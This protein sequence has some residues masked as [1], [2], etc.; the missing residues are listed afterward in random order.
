MTYTKNCDC[1]CGCNLEL[2][3]FVPLRGHTEC[4][5][6]AAGRCISDHYARTHAVRTAA[7]E[8]DRKCAEA[9]QKSFDTAMR[10]IDDAFQHSRTAQEYRKIFKDR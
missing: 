8:L 3:S 5:Y 10:W 6:C 9:A 4:D 1:F 2:H 7:T